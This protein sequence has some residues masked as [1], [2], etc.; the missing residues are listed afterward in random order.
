MDPGILQEFRGEEWRRGAKIPYKFQGEWRPGAI[1]HQ[2]MGAQA[3]IHHQQIGAQTPIHH[4]QM[5]AQAPIH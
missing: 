4:Q 2:Q 3:P 5:G 1:H